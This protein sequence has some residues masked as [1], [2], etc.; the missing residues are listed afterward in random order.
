MNKLISLFGVII[1][2]IIIGFVFF[3]NSIN[4][5]SVFVEKIYSKYE[6]N[7]GEDL[8]SQLLFLDNSKILS[9]KKIVSKNNSREAS[10]I[11]L[12]LELRTNWLESE[13]EKNLFYQT[14]FYENNCKA[15][16]H[17]TKLISLQKEF[18][19]K[20]NKNQ[21]LIK[22]TNINIE[23]LPN[24]NELKQTISNNEKELKKI[25]EEC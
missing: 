21:N 4:S 12:L 7:Q 2:L 19:Q 18:L 25:R 15:L 10:L 9:L 16:P 14:L 8:F 20:I 3:N 6:L 13:K 24:I 1:V 22:N 11:K 17:L 23:G 5:D